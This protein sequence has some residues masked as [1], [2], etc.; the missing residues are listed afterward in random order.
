MPDADLR[1]Q[2]WHQAFAD[3]VK[4]M[5]KVRWM[6]LAEG[7]ALSRAEIIGIATIA[8]ALAGSEEIALKHL[9]QALVQQG[10]SWQLR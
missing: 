3:G 4:G 5:G 6:A 7:L 8:Q 2:L 9:Q 10:Q 1:L